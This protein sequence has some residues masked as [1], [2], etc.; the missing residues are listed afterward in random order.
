[1]YID[2]YELLEV[3]KNK[4]GNL[5]NNGGCYVLVND[6]YVWLSVAD[7]VAVIDECMVYDEDDF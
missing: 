5:D 1:M 7:V 6:E 3:L 4:Y 2:K